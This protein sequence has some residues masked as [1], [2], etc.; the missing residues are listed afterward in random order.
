[1]ADSAQTPQQVLE[2]RTFFKEKDNASPLDLNTTFLSGFSSDGLLAWIVTDS[3]KRLEVWETA[4]GSSAGFWSS[5][6]VGSITC[7]EECVVRDSG[8]RLFLV[9]V[10][11]S[12]RNCGLAI[13]HAAKGALLRLI[14]LDFI[15]SSIH[16]LTNNSGTVPAV[17][18]GHFLSYFKGAA[19]L[20][21]Y[22]GIVMVVD[23]QLD[24][25]KG[26]VTGGGGGGESGRLLL[27]NNKQPRSKE[28]F[29]ALSEQALDNGEFL[30]ADLTSKSCTATQSGHVVQITS[31]YMA[32]LS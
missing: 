26:R 31:P 14:A 3:G 25:L 7:V 9:G 2:P 29:M 23:L 4:D 6:S 19:V 20:G 22:G 15:I 1:M 8:T 18:G 11:K 21:G 27:L 17:D 12:D 28:E 5:S 13:V 32:N 24:Q 16:C 30:A 10:S